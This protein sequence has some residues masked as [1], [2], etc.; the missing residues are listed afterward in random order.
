MILSADGYVVTNNHVIDGAERLE[1]TLNDN[2]TYNAVVVGTDPA[3]DVALLKI[4]A[5]D[6]PVIPIG[7]SD[8]LRVGEWVL[9]VGNPFGFTSTVTTGIVS[10]K[11]RSVA[12]GMN[13]GRQ[14]GHR[15]LH[16]GLMPP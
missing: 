5:N 8:N 10:A 15:E 1:V 2:S 3:T 13:G 16:P 12:A 11:A 4:E 6:L 9:A 14:D 7:D